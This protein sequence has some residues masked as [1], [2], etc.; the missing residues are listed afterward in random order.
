MALIYRYPLAS[1]SHILSRLALISLL[2]L[3]PSVALSKAFECPDWQADRAQTEIQHLHDKI[4]QWDN[5]YYVQ[6]QA[7]VDD[8][9]YDRARATLAQWNGCFPALAMAASKPQS[10]GGGTVAHPV[11]HTGLHKLHTADA[12]ADWLAAHRH[13]ELW[14]QPKVDGVAVTLVYHS[15]RLVRMISRGDGSRGQDW[16]RHALLIPAIRN[17]I[18]DD[19]AELV[20]QGEVYWRFDRHIQADGSANGRGRASGAMASN[21]LTS[22]QAESLGIFIWEWPR[23][24]ATLP[25]R[26]RGLRQLGY[27]TGVYTHRVTLLADV[28]QWRN[29]WYHAA[30]PFATDGIVL[31]QSRRP[32]AATWLP[33]PP[34]WATAWKYPAQTALARVVNVEFP[35]GRTG[36]IVPVVE[37]AP[38]ELDDRE[39]RRVSSGS[40]E[41]WHNMDIRPGDQLRIALAGQTIPQIV[42]VMLPASLRQPLQIPDPH[43]YTPL[44][45]WHPAKGCRAQF[46][47]RTEWLGEQLGFR[48]I[49]EKRWQALVDADLLPDLVAWLDIPIETLTA[50]P[51]I[52]ATRAQNL[53]RNFRAARARD[54]RD[55]MTALGM[56][57]ASRLNTEFWHGEDF[58]SLSARKLD[59]WQQLPGIGPGR[60]QEIMAFLE[61]PEINALQN[62]L[63][64]HGIAGF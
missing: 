16:T 48:G 5:A 61:H 40:F 47:A 55:W 35:V 39:I 62:R 37:I 57:A 36:K 51:G 11:V 50:L 23:G 8:A 34:G 59:E 15:G 52:G 32:A 6:H 63:A 29:S 25:A 7:L 43:D 24:P 3:P 13:G 2:A 22:R 18:P 4:T 27:D 9:V 49:G 17:R 41:Q 56:P 64:A 53:Q 46:L 31:K 45:C 12:V 19:R 26:V 1:C 33:Q 58:A 42:D 54:F 21:T 38:T 14:I 44:T 30:L 10:V 20:L 28:R 60:A